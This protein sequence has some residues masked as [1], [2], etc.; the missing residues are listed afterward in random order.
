MRRVDTD[1]FSVEYP[2]DVT[3][4]PFAV[5]E[6]PLLMMVFRR[7][8][9]QEI[10]FETKPGARAKTILFDKDILIIVVRR[11]ADTPD[12]GDGEQVPDIISRRLSGEGN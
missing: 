5:Q 1:Y 8:D 6:P 7:R 9:G 2:E 4:R 11:D 12:L 3:C 10:H